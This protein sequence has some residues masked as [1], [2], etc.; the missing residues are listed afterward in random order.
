MIGCRYFW[1]LGIGAFLLIGC[2]PEIN[3]K[4]SGN[5]FYPGTA[6]FTTEV[7]L[8]GA[9]LSGFTSNELFLS[10]QQASIGALLSKQLKRTG[11]GQFKQA[12]M[13]DEAGFGNRLEF[14]NIM[15]CEGASGLKA[16]AFKQQPDSRNT[17]NIGAQGLYHN[18]G[19]PK[20]SIVE[21][22]SNT[23][24]QN[25]P[26]FK[27]MASSGGTSAVD[28]AERLN[29]TFFFFWP[30]EADVYKFAMA[31]GTGTINGEAI[32][33]AITYKLN[34]N[35]I[36]KRLTGRG[37]SGVICNVPDVTTL[38]YF[39][40]IPYNAVELTQAEADQLNILYLYDPSLRFKAGKNPFV[41]R[42]GIT[43]RF[44]RPD[45]LIPIRINMDSVKCQGYGTSLP[46]NDQDVL[47]STEVS[48]IKNAIQNY[49]VAIEELANTFNLAVFDANRFFTKMLTSGFQADGI[50]YTGKYIYGGFISPDGIY[51]T[52]RG[53]AI[54]TNAIIQAIN[55]KFKARVPLCDINQFPTVAI[56]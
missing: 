11:G 34:A 23:L 51:P 1:L 4:V 33:P 31:G 7:A 10:G 25:N 32:T 5:G 52:Q 12:L 16:T 14:E 41:I 36:L 2:E 43:T 30:N 37:A 24:A 3:Q 47:T 50:I 18:L 46:L 6:V 56:P 26:Y 21:M 20:A 48:D 54:L 42:D 27:R 35:Q 45:E 15:D 53:N 17:A 22:S 39:T 38:P 28:E 44:A 13:F 49:N 9:F 40:Y 19:I 8:G 29:P 55:D